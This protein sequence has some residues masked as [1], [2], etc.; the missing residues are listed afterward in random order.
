LFLGYL[1]DADDRAVVVRSSDGGQSFTLVQSIV[2]DDQPTVTT[3]PGQ[4]AGSGSVWVTFNQSG[5]MAAAGAPVTGLGAVGSF[6]ATE[7]I[8]GGTGNFGDISVG[9]KGQVMVVWQY[10]AGNEQGPDDLLSS[11]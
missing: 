6:G 1:N 4:T 9:P 11:L 5:G 3:G 10:P 7:A 2:A 8:P